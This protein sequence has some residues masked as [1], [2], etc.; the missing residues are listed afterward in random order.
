[1]RWKCM[2]HITVDHVSVQVAMFMIAAENQCVRIRTA[3]VAAILRQ[4]IAWHDQQ[5]AGELTS[6][7]AT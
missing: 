7:L 5:T 2:H 4:E 3:Y 6:R 1:M